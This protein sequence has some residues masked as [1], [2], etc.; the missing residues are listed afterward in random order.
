[1]SATGR[2]IGC[3][4]FSALLLSFPAKAQT[5]A[6]AILAQMQ[7]VADWE[8]AHLDQADIPP[9]ADAKLPR[10]WIR[11]TFYAGLTALA[12]R[13]P[14][15]KYADAIFAH[16]ERE[17]WQLG[18]R[19]FH[20]DD[21]LIAQTWIWAYG[22]KH[23]P[24]MIAAARQRFDAIIKAAPSGS[25]LMSVPEDCF[26]WCWSDAL[27]MAPPGWVAL[28][29]V[30]HD[31]RY[32]AYADKEYRAAT[33]QLFDPDQSLFYRDSTFKGRTGPDGRKLFWSRGNGWVYAGLARILAALPSESPSRP[34]YRDLFLRMSRKVARL[35]KPDGCWPPALLDPRK[36]SSSETSGTALFTFGLAWGVKNGLLS[37]TSYRANAEQGWA[38]LIGAVGSDGKLGWVQSQSDQPDS[39]RKWDSQAFG[40]GAFLLAGAAFYDLGGHR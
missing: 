8:L 19:L 14:D 20:A 37:D 21:Q 26:R 33:A 17:H 4:A 22:R 32:L 13:T 24:E 31:P 2:V 27:F 5:S 23:H 6:P 16:G 36:D 28:S 18:P 12:D 1:M 7:R 9:S 39:V 25:L 29:N 38:C 40:V 11:S 30:T 34:F 10:G 3:L 15:P 35:Q